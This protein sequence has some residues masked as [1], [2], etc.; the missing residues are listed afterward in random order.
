MRLLRAIGSRATREVHVR[1]AAEAYAVYIDLA[2]ADWHAVR[3]TAVGWS[4]VQSPPVRFRRSSGMQPL[5]FPERGIA[6]DRLRPFLNVTASDFT[7]VVAYLLAAFSCG[8]L[9]ERF[10]GC[11][12]DARRESL[13][14]GASSPVRG[15]IRMLVE[16]ALKSQSV[17]IAEQLVDPPLDRLPGVIERIL[18]RQ[19]GVVEQEMM[20]RGQIESKVAS[21][22][23]RQRLARLLHDA[24]A[25]VVALRLGFASAR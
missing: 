21:G 10:S 20:P 1:V 15:S 17:G 25:L 13:A 2:D 23:L 4:I 3:V 22:S 8:R 24:E 11:S 9:A 18:F 7:L 19:I 14:A 6:I 5:P 16:H 12:A